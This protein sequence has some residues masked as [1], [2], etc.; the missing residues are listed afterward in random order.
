[1]QPETRTPLDRFDKPGERWTGVGKALR[2]VI[3]YRIIGY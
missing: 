1:M 2:L 3:G